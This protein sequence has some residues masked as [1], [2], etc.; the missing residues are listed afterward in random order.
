[1][2]GE[3]GGGC[4]GRH[5]LEFAQHPFTGQSPADAQGKTQNLENVNVL[6]RPSTTPTAWEAAAHGVITFNCLAPQL[7]NKS[8]A[9]W[10]AAVRMRRYV[11]QALALDAAT[12]IAECRDLVVMLHA[13][14]QLKVAVQRHVRVTTATLLHL[15]QL[16]Q[17]LLLL[18]TLR[19]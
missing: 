11:S 3:W 14:V 4:G 18:Q 16:L 1:M 5:W 12:S 13:I 6:E 10:Q 15:E 8:G 19:P 2:E 9:V 7:I 17:L